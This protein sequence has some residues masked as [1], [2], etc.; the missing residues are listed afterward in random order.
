M[1]L[2]NAH[3]HTW[4]HQPVY[5]SRN[6]IA[7]IVWSSH[8]QA[9]NGSGI[10]YDRSGDLF[11]RSLKLE[12]ERWKRKFLFPDFFLE[13]SGETTKFYNDFSAFKVSM[14]DK[15]SS[16]DSFPWRNIGSSRGTNLR[17]IRSNSMFHLKKSNFEGAMV[18]IIRAC[19]GREETGSK[20]MAGN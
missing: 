3:W 1:I 16:I 12:T 2:V 11:R 6:F 19:V 18:A 15:I 8:G 13:E 5:A 7:T 9:R 17:V 4:R 14:L 10:K 20:W